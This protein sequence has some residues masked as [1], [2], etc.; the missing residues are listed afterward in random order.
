MRFSLFYKITLAFLICMGQA[1]AG[2]P[3][4]YNPIPIDPPFSFSERLIDLTP[5]IAK[6][7][8]DGKPILIYMGAQDCPP[9]KQ[10][11]QFLEKNHKALASTYES[12]VVV[13]VR[14]WLK[15]P[16][17]VFQVADKR[18]SLD[19]FKAA[20]GDGN[21]SYTWPYWWL[22]TPDLRQLKQLPRGSKYYLE[23]E[24]HKNLF[25]VENIPAK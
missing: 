4:N 12:L 13:D 3:D 1:I 17:L 24:Q 23:V 19:E 2:I 7:K 22:I 9:C 25:R 5:A 8:K 15:G 6:A 16:K 10:Y 11:E 18:Y 20:V 21:R 14:S